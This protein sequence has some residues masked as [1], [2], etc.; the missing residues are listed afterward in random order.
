MI[1]THKIRK[2]GG[3]GVVNLGKKRKSPDHTNAFPSPGILLPPQR[4]TCWNL[5]FWALIIGISKWEWLGTGQGEATGLEDIG[6][7]RQ[8]QER[9][10]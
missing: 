10:N 2:P 6:K 5:G 8:L 9:E 1:S 7:G 4:R 3:G